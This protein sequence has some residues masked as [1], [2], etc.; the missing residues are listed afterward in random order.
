MRTRVLGAFLLAALILFFPSQAFC[1]DSDA[2]SLDEKIDSAWDATT[3]L[4]YLSEIA[5]SKEIGKAISTSEKLARFQ[6]SAGLEWLTGKL[7]ALETSFRVA[8]FANFSYQCI[9]AETY[10]DFS[11]KF[12]KLLEHV[13]YCAVY[14]GAEITLDVAVAAIVAAFPGLGLMAALPLEAMFATLLRGMGRDVVGD[15]SG[16]MVEWLQGKKE[17]SALKKKLFKARNSVFE[18]LNQP[19]DSDPLPRMPGDSTIDNS[20][21][22]M[23]GI[24][25]PGG[26]PS[27][28]GSGA[29]MPGYE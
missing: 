4:G 22:P 7:W 25:V 10:D 28:S 29:G 19:S 21:T 3:V 1:R 18:E 5:A 9:V 8:Q 24:T 15:V 13:L 16:R 27:D 6:D 12:D 17:Y 23:K 11:P 14:S 26:D 2:S 20:K